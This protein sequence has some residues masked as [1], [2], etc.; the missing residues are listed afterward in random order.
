MYLVEKPHK[1]DKRNALSI[2]LANIRMKN[3]LIILIIFL[4]SCFPSMQT[5]PDPHSIEFEESKFERIISHFE[6]KPEIKG[7]NI[8]NAPKEIPVNVVD[9]MEEIGF[10]EFRNLGDYKVFFCGYGVVGK[11]WG[12]IHGKFLE[13]E[14]D[15]PILIKGNN[16]QLNLTFLEHLKGNWFRFGAG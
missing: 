12:F 7:F 3:L 14:I 11:G 15:G 13:E 8:E 6:S 1:S 10:L 16:K 9:D 5:G 2:T 4:T